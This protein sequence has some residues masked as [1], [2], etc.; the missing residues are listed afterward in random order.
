MSLIDSNVPRWLIRGGREL[1]KDLSSMER[2]PQLWLR[3][4]WPS[5]RR[6]RKAWLGPLRRTLGG[7]L[8]EAGEAK[9]FLW[10]MRYSWIFLQSSRN[11]ATQFKDLPL[12]CYVADPQANKCIHQILDMSAV[13]SPFIS[14][15]VSECKL[16]CTMA[17]TILRALFEAAQRSI[18]NHPTS[19]PIDGGRNLVRSTS[20]ALP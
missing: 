19:G 17:L 20:R 2:I 4:V 13:L 6:I 16:P 10:S 18:P 15:N 1:C 14:K 3:S 9:V 11:I 8:G 5:T 7:G 12:L